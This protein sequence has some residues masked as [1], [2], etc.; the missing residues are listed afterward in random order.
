MLAQ[1]LPKRKRDQHQLDI[2]LHFRLTV[3]AVALLIMEM[4]GYAV[5]QKREQRL[6]ARGEKLPAH[7]VRMLHLQYLKQNSSSGGF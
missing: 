3:V 5:C 7:W 4:K 1:R 2:H 6:R